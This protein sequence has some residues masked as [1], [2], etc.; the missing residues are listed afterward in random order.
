MT[1][2]SLHSSSTKVHIPQLSGTR[3]C[4]TNT[5][6]GSKLNCSK[7]GH[8]QRCCETKAQQRT[9]KRT[10]NFECMLEVQ[11][12]DILEVRSLVF[13][14]QQWRKGKNHEKSHENDHN[15]VNCE[16]NLTKVGSNESHNQ[17]GE[18][19]IFLI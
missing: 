16:P 12:Q 7:K 8:L 6:L 9:A 13:C 3:D 5:G 15:S 11:F 14:R 18:E 2:R 19:C 4:T 10:A 17:G 1:R